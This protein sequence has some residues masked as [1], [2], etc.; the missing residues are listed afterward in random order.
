MLASIE[1]A[2]LEAV[3]PSRVD[4]MGDWLVPL[5]SGTVGRARS[6]VPLTHDAADLRYIAPIEQRYREAGIEPM[7]RL[8]NGPNWVLF[9]NALSGRGYDC[10]KPTLVQI[11]SVADLIRHG[12]LSKVEISPTPSQ[13]W[14]SLYTSDGFDPEDGANRVKLMSRARSGQFFSVREP[15]SGQ[16][17]A[18]GMAAFDHG[19][20]SAHGMRC[21]PAHRRKGHARSIV[22]AMSYVAHRQGVPGMFLQVEKENSG[23]VALYENLGFRTQWQYDYWAKPNTPV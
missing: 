20:A 10:S 4:H 13:D 21:L 22:C 7:F 9:R 15:S 6:A 2:T 17:I 19:W 12:S 23:A 3:V 1:Q 8:P 5:E 11:A 18:T 16:L 14:A